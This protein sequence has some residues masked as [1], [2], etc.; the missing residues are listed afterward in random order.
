VRLLSKGYLSD[1]APGFFTGFEEKSMETGCRLA[2]DFVHRAAFRVSLL[3]R[4]AQ[5]SSGKIIA[6]VILFL[7]LCVTAGNENAAGQETQAAGEAVSVERFPVGAIQSPDGL[8]RSIFDTPLEA[9]DNPLSADAQ[10]LLG[11]NVVYRLSSAYELYDKEHTAEYYAVLFDFTKTADITSSMKDGDVIGKIDGSDPKL[12]VFC[13]TIDPYLVINCERSPYYYDGFYWF[14]PAFLFRS[15]DTVWLSFA[16]ADNIDDV[17]IVIA[18]HVRDDPPGFTY[19]PSV[20][21]R[22]KTQLAEYPRPL[23]DIEKGRIAG[24]ESRFYRREGLSTHATERYAGGYQ[25][26]LCW[27]EGFDEYLK[28]EYTLNDD[29]WIYGSVVTY[30]V[31][32]K[33]GYLFIRDF[34]EETLENMYEERLEIV[35]EILSREN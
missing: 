2:R 21:V 18:E 32:V 10:K 33:C 23:T 27:Q 25:Y 13:R 34:K 5:A 3:A 9:A 30:D 7:A 35:K 17:L 6:S 26:L 11:T 4:Q 31:W 22:F 1:Y 19:Y 8:V 16:P 14:Y 20:R 29:I 24:Y 12:L 15:G 28:N